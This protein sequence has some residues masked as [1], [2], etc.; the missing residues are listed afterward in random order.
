M[1][2]FRT[3][4]LGSP[5]KP[6]TRPSVVSSTRRSTFARSRWF[7]LA[8][9]LTWSFAY[10]GEMSGSRPEP[11]EVTASAGTWDWGTP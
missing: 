4:T 9:R 3:L 7:S 2:S 10:A 8:T 6:R 11:E 5:M 1:F